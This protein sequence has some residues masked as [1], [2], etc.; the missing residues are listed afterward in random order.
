[1]KRISILLSILIL[2]FVATNALAISKEAI[3]GNVDSLVTMIDEGKA[4]TELKADAFEPYAFVIEADGKVLL[5]PSLTGKNLKEENLSAYTA[6]MQATEKG[7]WVEYEY[8]GKTKHTYAKI[9]KNN[10]IVGSG[11]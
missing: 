5:H 2:M 10:L 1:M 8:E 11:Y 4:V 9:T 3:S 6:L 7:V